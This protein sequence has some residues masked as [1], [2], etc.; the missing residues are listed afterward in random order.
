MHVPWLSIFW[1]VLSWVLFCFC[2]FGIKG[3]SNVGS[4]CWRPH[5]TCSYIFCWHKWSHWWRQQS[6]VWNA[7]NRVFLFQSSLICLM[8]YTLH[9]SP[10]L[11][12]NT[13]F[14]FC[15][16]K[17]FLLWLLLFDYVNIEK[18]CLEHLLWKFLIANAAFGW[19]L[20]NCLLLSWRYA[21]CIDAPLSICCRTVA[22]TNMNETSS[23]SH[24]I[25]SIVF[26]QR[27]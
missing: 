4:I 6:K 19:Y 10:E 22:A 3:T 14:S 23:R 7:V 25:F 20:R 8:L 27:R 9:Q 1:S 5:Q 24:A 26:T 11:F 15:I 21:L 2:F 17:F 18:H 13:L 16:L 12:V